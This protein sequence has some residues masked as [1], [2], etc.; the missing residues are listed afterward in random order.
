[1]NDLDSDLL[2]C[3]F[4]SPKYASA[5]VPTVCVVHDLQYRTYPQFF[6]PEDV[7]HRHGVF[8][9]AVRQATALVAVS[10]YT[11]Q[12]IL[13]HRNADPSRVRTIHHRLGRRIG[14]DEP[15]AKEILDSHGV[16][17]ERYLLY[18]ANF[19][20]HKNHEMLLLAFELATRNG[21]PEDVQL[22]CTGAPD[23]RQQFLV[24]AAERMGIGRRVRFPGYVSNEEF[25]SLLRGSRGLIFPSLYEG[26]GMPIVEA[27]EAG[28]PI[29]CSNRTALPEVADG[30][31]IL[32]DPRIPFQISAAMVQLCCDEER[33]ALLVAAGK[34]RAA[35]FN[36]VDLMV[37]EY[38][39]LFQQSMKSFPSRSRK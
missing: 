9:D 6:E 10:N 35:R 4:T 17:P 14:L 19:W 20:R 24:A 3:P 7:A 1:L 39:D 25:S 11:R 15:I 12:S 38:W 26:F 27:M 34:S 13:I 32:F 16:I 23:K 8:A 2:F 36:D 30:A 31:A 29:A 28:V 37:A 22:V 5:D 33:R 21:L 18:P